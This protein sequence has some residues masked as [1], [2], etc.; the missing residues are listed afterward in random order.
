[1]KCVLCVAGDHSPQLA[2]QEHNNAAWIQAPV[3]QQ[4]GNNELPASPCMPPAA[5]WPPPP[6]PHEPKC[7]RRPGT[8]AAWQQRHGLELKVQC[9]PLI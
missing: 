9:E 3:V 4:S 8:R 1:M 6:P 2:E 7:C 5:A